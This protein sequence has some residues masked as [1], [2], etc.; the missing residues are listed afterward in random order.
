MTSSQRS[1]IPSQP[2]GPPLPT[3]SSPKINYDEHKPVVLKLKENKNSSKFIIPIYSL[4]KE[5]KEKENAE[6]SWI[7]TITEPSLLKYDSLFRTR[8]EG[9]NHLKQQIQVN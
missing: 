8:F 9:L 5:N 4:N 1:L 7:H 6:H 2:S 3:T